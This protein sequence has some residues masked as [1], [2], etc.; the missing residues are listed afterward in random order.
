M[1]GHLNG[2]AKERDKPFFPD[3][4]NEKER[5][6][7]VDRIPS[8]MLFPSTACLSDG[9]QPWVFPFHSSAAA[10]ASLSLLLV[11]GFVFLSL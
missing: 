9:I 5:R 4:H 10:D 3:G 11:A 1:D 8:G 2:H 6:T 7:T